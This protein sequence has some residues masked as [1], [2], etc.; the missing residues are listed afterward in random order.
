MTPVPDRRGAEA[1]GERTIPVPGAEK[2]HRSSTQKLA[3]ELR[4]AAL[5]SRQFARAH[6]SPEVG[7]SFTRLAAKWEA[8]AEA[9]ETGP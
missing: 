1:G 2:P 5:R 9:I 8:E 4:E 3:A 6:K 7:E